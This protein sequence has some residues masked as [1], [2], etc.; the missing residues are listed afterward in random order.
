MMRRLETSQLPLIKRCYQETVSQINFRR[1]GVEFCHI[2][3]VTR[4][5]LSD[6]FFCYIAHRH[7]N[8]SLQEK[9]TFAFFDQ[10]H[11]GAEFIEPHLP[12]Q[13]WW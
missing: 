11:G 6:L 13:S 3:L 9:P 10:N 4:D 8:R 2:R 5:P 12:P 7:R 1:W